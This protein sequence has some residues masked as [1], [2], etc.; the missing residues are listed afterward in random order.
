MFLF[1]S[2]I[3]FFSE[4][5]KLLNRLENPNYQKNSVNAD[6]GT[7]YT[8]DPEVVKEKMGFEVIP[9][10]NSGLGVIHKASMNLD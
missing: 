3:L 8:V 7:A 1:D 9:R 2:D 10:F 5:K 6:V 4:P